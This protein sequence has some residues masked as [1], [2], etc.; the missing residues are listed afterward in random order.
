LVFEN[1]EKGDKSMARRRF[2]EEKATQAAARLLKLRGGTMSYLKLI[3][4][5]YLAERESLTRFGAPLTYDRYVSMPHGPVVSATLDRIN[6]HE[7]YQGG[8]WD[9]HITP[10]HN[11]EVSLREMEA[12]PNGALSPAEEA[13]IDEIFA[14]YGHL[15]R[16][17]L[18]KLTHDLPE[19]T[20]PQGTSLPIN[21]ADILLAE[22][23]SEEDVAEMRGNWDEAGYAASLFS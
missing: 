14:R 20:D 5:L 10:K 4:L 6:E 18:V 3:K 17:E 23:Y 7:I 19:W 11:Y 13:L 9:T 21:P 1:A 12:V 15:G 2:S 22:G 8:Y 16:W